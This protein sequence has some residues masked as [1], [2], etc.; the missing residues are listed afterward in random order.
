[1]SIAERKVTS[2]VSDIVI[3]KMTEHDL[4]EVV[5]IEEQSGLSRWGWAAYYAELQSGNRDLLLVALP[6]RSPIV[7]ERRLAGYIVARE[8]AG[9]LHINNVAVREEYRRRGIGRS[10]LWKILEEARNLGVTAAFLEVRSSNRPAQALYEQCGFRAISRR[11]NYYTDPPEDAVV[12]SLA[13]K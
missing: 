8:T 3:G 1:M 2:S 12:M 11:S 7:E 6:L 10:L 4:V 13:L 5:E 9:E